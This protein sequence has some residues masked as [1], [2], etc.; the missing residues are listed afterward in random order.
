MESLGTRVY[1][2]LAAVAVLLG[3]SL[4]PERRPARR[5]ARPRE[6]ILKR[7]RLVREAGK[8]CMSYAPRCCI[9]VVHEMR[10]AYA[11]GI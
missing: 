1:G 2:V 8:K 10:Q 11:G 6:A 7:R 3:E 9:G 5:P 4:Q